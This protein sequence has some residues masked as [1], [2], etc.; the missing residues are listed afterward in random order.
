MLTFRNGVSG[1]AIPVIVVDDT[2]T[3]WMS[4]IDLPGIAGIAR[5]VSSASSW[6]VIEVVVWLLPVALVVFR[7]WRHLL[8]YLVA[9]Q[10]AQYVHAL[11]TTAMKRD[12]LLVE[13]VSR[14]FQAGNADQDDAAARAAHLRRLA[15]RLAA[16]RRRGDENA[17]YA[18]AA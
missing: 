5:V 16:A 10:L 17:V 4:G 14:Q 1:A 18:A 13:I 15:H 8:V 6:W 12:F 9:S 2:V 11:F 7:R 3:R